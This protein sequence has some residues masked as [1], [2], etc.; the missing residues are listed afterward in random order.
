MPEMTGYERDQIRAIERWKAQPPAVVAE[1]AGILLAPITWLAQRLIPA[2]AIETALAGGNAIARDTSG[3]RDLLERAGVDSVAR[4]RAK[5][6]PLCDMLAESVHNRAVGVATM[7][8][9]AAG[10]VGLA[11]APLD[12]P[13][14]IVLA[15]RTIHRIGLCYGFQ[16]TTDSDERFALAV[17]SAA[18]ANSMEEK[19]IAVAVLGSA[20]EW[21]GVA[22][23]AAGRQLGREATILG[24]RALARQLGVNAARRRALSAIPV[25]GAA[26]GAAVNGGFLNEV[27]WAARRS[28]QERWLRYKLE[29]A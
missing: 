14:V 1:A 9:A 26:T 22:E 4:L 3:T 13:A 24:I 28:F 20:G 17:L 7:E 6:L 29:L 2:A 25:V 15:L 16:S 10:A 11:A 12:V 5:D 27:A 18:G 8:G 19:K 23:M 21:T